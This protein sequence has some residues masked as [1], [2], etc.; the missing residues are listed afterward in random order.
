VARRMV[1]IAE[2]RGPA[3]GTIGTIVNL[4][5]ISGQRTFRGMMGYSIATAAVDQLTRSLAVAL[6]PQR[7]RVNG[8][9]YAS[10]LSAALVEQLR[11]QPAL[12]GAIVEA[13]PLGRIADAG[14]LS[15]AVQFLASDASDFITG[16]VLTVD[17]GRSLLDTVRAPHS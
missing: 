8:V 14:E 17:G 15:E 16:Q 2:K 3:E 9:A 1:S 13:T 7:V 4:S 12:R 11:E 5:S 6:A 10:L